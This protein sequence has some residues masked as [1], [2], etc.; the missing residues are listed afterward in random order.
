MA[1]EI[2]AEIAP[3][4]DVMCVLCVRARR[5]ILFA[6]PERHPACIKLADFGTS[7]IFGVHSKALSMPTGTPG[8]AAAELFDETGCRQTT[9]LDLWSCGV[10][11]YLML[12]GFPPFA[13]PTDDENMEQQLAMRNAITSARYDFPSPEWDQISQEAISLVRSLLQKDTRKRLSAPDVLVH[14]WVQRPPADGSVG[15]AEGRSRASRKFRKAVL[16]VMAAHRMEFLVKRLV[17]DQHDEEDAAVP[18]PNMRNG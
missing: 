13:W 10:V 7:A 8:Y 16:G 17:A 11:L 15:A 18:L 9:A 4:A 2:H 5:S 14:P 3:S 1:A 12:C 6:T